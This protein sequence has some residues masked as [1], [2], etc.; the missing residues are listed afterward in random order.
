MENDIEARPNSETVQSILKRYEREWQGSHI[1]FRIIDTFYWRTFQIWPNHPLRPKLY[2]STAANLVDHAVDTQLGFKPKITVLPSNDSETEKERTA[3]CE[4]FLTAVFENASLQEPSLPWKMLYR[5]GTMYGYFVGEGPRLDLASQP[6]EPERRDGEKE[7]R[8][9]ERVGAYDFKLRDW[10]PIRLSAPH[11]ARVL[12]D[13]LEKRPKVVLR[14]KDYY[15]DEL[16]KLST[17]KV[18]SGKAKFPWL[19]RKDA[20]SNEIIKCVEIWNEDWHGVFRKEGE[21]IFV[22]PNTWGFCPFGHGFSGWGMEKTEPEE[23]ITT[24]LAIG[25]LHHV[26]DSLIAQAQ[27]FSSAQNLAIVDRKSVV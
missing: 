20:D 2:P 17:K 23:S 1:L 15:A 11:P 6:K 19:W 12:L 8:F 22:E 5:Y 16:E 4:R 21:E 3:K 13:P 9:K 7:A 24:S 26:R 18:K 14:Y 10:C 27:Q 25:I